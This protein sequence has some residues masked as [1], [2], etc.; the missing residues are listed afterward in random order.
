MLPFAKAQVSDRVSDKPHKPPLELGISL[1]WELSHCARGSWTEHKGMARNTCCR[2]WKDGRRL[3][4][5]HP[6][7][8]GSLRAQRMLRSR[9][10]SHRPSV[11]LVANTPQPF[12]ERRSAFLP[13]RQGKQDAGHIPAHIDKAL[14]N[15]TNTL[16]SSN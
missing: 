5:K 3:P 16:L 1:L 15:S 8:V 6:G 9:N 12:K 2:G 4:T 10:P 13:H 7:I 11:E 14:H